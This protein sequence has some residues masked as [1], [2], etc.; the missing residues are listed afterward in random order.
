VTGLDALVFAILLISGIFA[1]I[2]GFV[3]ELLTLAAWAGAALT[4]LYGFEY[5]V[6]YAR[7]LVTVQAVA[8]IGT[9]LLIFMAVLVVLTVLTRLLAR[10]V[11]DSSLSTLDRS[12][13]L[14]FGILRGALLLSF[15][16]VLVAWAV[17]RDDF[18][19][20]ISEARTLPL[21][22]T[23]AALLYALVPAHLQ[24]EDPPDID[25][26]ALEL[27][28]SFEELVNPQPKPAGPHRASGYKD[29]ERKDLKRLIESSQ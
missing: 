7:D 14:V 24:P 20:W 1:Y 3:H 26:D 29:R 18:P 10:R 19:D 5:V 15:I 8:D 12:L 13:G 22:E 6:P 2:R 27:G 28:Y 17:P 4:T 9:G 11:Q 25:E 23:G 16:W 21:I